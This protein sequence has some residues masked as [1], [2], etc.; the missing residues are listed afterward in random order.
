[1]DYWISSLLLSCSLSPFISKRGRGRTGRPFQDGK[2]E[3]KRRNAPVDRDKSC[4]HGMFVAFTPKIGDPW[5]VVLFL[6]PCA[7]C[8]KTTEPFSR[9]LQFPPISQ[10]FFVVPLRPPHHPLCPPYLFAKKSCQARRRFS[11]SPT[12]PLVTASSIR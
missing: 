9:P 5:G 10:N 7:R 3:K 2:G 8:R 6:P 4:L 11:S 12:A 1:M